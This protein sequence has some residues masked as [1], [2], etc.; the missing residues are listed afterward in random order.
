MN[1]T[2]ST[3]TT[4]LAAALGVAA[5][6]VMAPALLFA[7]AGPA[8]AGWFLNDDDN[9]NGFTYGSTGDPDCTRPRAR[10]PLPNSACPIGSRL[11]IVALPT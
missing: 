3:K 5:A 11:P 4:R 9:R 7:V 1:T 8:Q 6:A 2:H 10:I